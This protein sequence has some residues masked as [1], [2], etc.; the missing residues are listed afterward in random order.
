M[1]RVTHHKGPV[2]ALLRF[3]RF[4]LASISIPQS[5]ES[6]IRLGL[7]IRGIVAEYSCTIKRAI[8]LREVELLETPTCQTVNRNITSSLG[9][10]KMAYPT[11]VANALR[12]LPPQPNSN[13][14]CS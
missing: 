8:V 3:S 2:R 4:R 7:I 6:N 5:P 1:C 12:P 14:M 11:F 13:D 9:V 10:Q